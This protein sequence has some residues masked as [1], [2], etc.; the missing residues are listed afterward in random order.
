[1]RTDT[2]ILSLPAA[3]VPGKWTRVRAEC[4]LYVFMY[5]VGLFTALAKTQDQLTL[6]DG[7]SADAEPSERVA[8]ATARAVTCSDF[9][10]SIGFALSDSES[11]DLSELT[12]AADG[13]RGRG[14]LGDHQQPH[15]RHVRRTGV[16]HV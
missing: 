5:R 15:G 14:A 8:P 7:L 11:A 16:V 10:L 3:W 4:A 6:A 12:V 9:S 13:R 2:S 1:M